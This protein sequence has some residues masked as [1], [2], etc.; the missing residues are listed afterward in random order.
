MFG[1]E[2]YGIDPA[3]TNIL[4]TEPIL[5]F[6]SSQEVMC[7]ILFEEYGLAAVCRTTGMLHYFYLAS[8]D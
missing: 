5:N 8:Y 1:P 6:M 3:E 7:E 2:C 4:V